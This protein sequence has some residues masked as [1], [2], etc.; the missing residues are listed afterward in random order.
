MC[1]GYYNHTKPYQ[2]RWEGMDRFQG[3]IVHPQEWPEDLDHTG[4]RVVVIGSG[5]TASTLIPAIAQKAAHHG[6]SCMPV[7]SG[8]SVGTTIV[9][10]LSCMCPSRR[11]TRSQ[12]RS[13]RSVQLCR[14]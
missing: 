13:T 1:Q 9:A 4:K 7:S 2:P 11:H 3:V 14:K 10:P 6:R 5:S 12:T 8:R